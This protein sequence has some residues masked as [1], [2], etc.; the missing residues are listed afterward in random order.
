ME[1]KHYVTKQPMDHWRNQRGNQKIP[2]EKW[3]K[4]HDDTNPMGPSKSTSKRE[5]YSNTIVPQGTRKI[6]INNLT[7]HLNQLEKE[8]EEQQKTQS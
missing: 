1:A 7:F 4:K 3:N 6:S 5:M 2:R 8:E